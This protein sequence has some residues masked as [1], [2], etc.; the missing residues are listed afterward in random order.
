MLSLAEAPLAVLTRGAEV[1]M[2]AEYSVNRA[3]CQCQEIKKVFIK[4][5]LCGKN[6]WEGKCIRRGSNILSDS[7]H[8]CQQSWE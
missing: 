1:G 3:R 7:T 4:R 8:T 6:P 5:V 2:L